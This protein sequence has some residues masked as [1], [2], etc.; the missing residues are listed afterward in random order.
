MDPNRSDA[1]TT[2]GALDFEQADFGGAPGEA[3]V[4]AHCGVPIGDAYYTLGDVVHCPRCHDGVQ[5]QLARGPGMLGCLR[6]FGFGGVAAIA[7]A[8]LWA[9]VTYVTNYEIGLIAIAV[10]WLV[11]V[12]VRAGSGGIGGVPYQVLAIALTYLAIVATDVPEILDA[13]AA[14]PVEELIGEDVQAT[15]SLV[16]VDVDREEFERVGAEPRVEI[17]VITTDAEAAAETGIP[18]DQKGELEINGQ[19]IAAAFALALALPFMLGFENAIG[20]LIIGIALFEAW[21]QTRRA[22]LQIGGPFRVG[23]PTAG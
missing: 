6:A 16:D 1:A 4:C 2:S 14:M 21:R 5:D 12:A 17:S 9:G 15:E 18:I 11:G 8:A 13:W 22:R 23:G 10:G 20:V 7:G 3:L 19:V